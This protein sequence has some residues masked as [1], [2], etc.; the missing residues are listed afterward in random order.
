MRGEF[1]LRGIE[2]AGIPGDKLCL[3]GLEI[4]RQQ[5]LIALA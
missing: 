1:I 4:L 5:H 3:A 2:V